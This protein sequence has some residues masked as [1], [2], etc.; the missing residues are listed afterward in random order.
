M[1][2]RLEGVRLKIA[3]LLERGQ[4][5]GHFATDIPPLA[6]AHIL[7]VALGGAIEAPS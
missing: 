6:L 3:A 5:R 4:H 1:Q 7:E 2:E